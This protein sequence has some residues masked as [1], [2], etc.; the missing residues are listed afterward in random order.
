MPISSSGATRLKP[1]VIS[2]RLIVRVAHQF[3][4]LAR[5]ADITM[6][7]YRTLA[8]LQDGS[9]RAGEMALLAAVKKPTMSALLAGLRHKGWVSYKVDPID[10]RVLKV[11]LTAS[12]RSRL[13]RFDNEL[14][15]RFEQLIAGANV[16][17]VHAIL[18]EA[19]PILDENLARYRRTKSVDA[20]PGFKL[21]NAKRQA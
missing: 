2:A 13:H 17:R 1:K 11:I 8:Y 5:S 9:R 7:E 20:G 10:G 3:D 14:A 19:W 16:T 12:G 6:A 21:D 18:A 4:D 15:A